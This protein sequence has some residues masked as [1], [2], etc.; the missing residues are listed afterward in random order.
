MM[1][2]LDFH[3]YLFGC[4]GC[5]VVVNQGSKRAPACLDPDC[6]EFGKALIP[7]PEIIDR[8]NGDGW[9]YGKP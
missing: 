1:A 7:W 8:V 5:G 4:Q 9:K 2:S 6:G 3:F